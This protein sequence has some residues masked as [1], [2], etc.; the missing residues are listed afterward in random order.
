MT[1][2]DPKRVSI[3]ISSE[4]RDGIK[5]LSAKHGVKM[6]EMIRSLILVGQLNENAV[7]KAVKSVSG[8][9]AAE[10][11]AKKA[12]KARLSELSPEQVEALLQQVK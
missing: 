4:D 7:A 1:E 12:L 10:R 5:E 9:K 11:E 6:Y 8:D 2:I 3:A